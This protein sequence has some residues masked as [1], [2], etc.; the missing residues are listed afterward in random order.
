MHRLLAIPLLV[1]LLQ[2]SQIALAQVPSELAHNRMPSDEQPRDATSLHQRALHF[3]NQNNYESA[4][5]D[6]HA[7]IRVNPY[8]TP[9]YFLRG[10]IFAGKKEFA[11]AIE[12]FNTVIAQDA[13]VANAFHQRALAHQESRDYRHA[14]QDFDKALALEPHNALLMR[15][16]A[17]ANRDAGNYDQAVDDYEAAMRLGFSAVD[18]HP[19][20]DLLFF[21]GRFH[22][23]AQTLQQVIRTRPDN[24]HASLW[25]YLALGKANDDS[26]AARELAEL[27]TRASIDKR[28][29]AAVLE[30]YLGKIDESS[31]YAATEATDETLKT[32]RQCQAHFYVAEA[33]L[34]KG[35]KDD[36][37]SG[38]QVAKNQCAPNTAFFHGANAELKR[39][40]Q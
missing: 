2:S 4:L 8:Y 34:L 17:I 11:A 13:S 40:G 32:E 9:A 24:R 28:W 3:F 23:S 38:L 1:I 39:F 21:Q 26:G 27:A 25:R 22:Q 36:A 6:L 33:K 18:P 35:A 5:A 37:I 19:L 20:A 29:P 14:L 7:A 10:Q 16:R 12:D 15:D 31:L 30:F